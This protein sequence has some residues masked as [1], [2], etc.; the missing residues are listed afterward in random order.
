MM[1]GTAFV[2]DFLNSI[3]GPFNRTRD[4]R[5][6]R[7]PFGKAPQ[8]RNELFPQRLLPPLDVFRSL[9]CCNRQTPAIKMDLRLLLQPPIEPAPCRIISDHGQDVPVLG[10]RQPTGQA[11]QSQETTQN[12]PLSPVAGPITWARRGVTLRCR[13]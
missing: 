2:N 7:S 11:D 1:L 12:G 3:V 10:G 4:L 6:Q 8:G 13:K 5:I 9:E